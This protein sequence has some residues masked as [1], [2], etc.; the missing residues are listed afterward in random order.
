MESKYM[1]HKTHMEYFSL[2]QTIIFKFAATLTLYQKLERMSMLRRLLFLDIPFVL[3]GES[4]LT[5][6]IVI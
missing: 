5:F 1:K 3:R 2:Q 4:V 6:M